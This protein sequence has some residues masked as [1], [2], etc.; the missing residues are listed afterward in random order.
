MA[1]L[2][3]VTSS[4]SVVID[5]LDPAQSPANAELIRNDWSKFLNRHCTALDQ[6]SLPLNLGETRSA[7]TFYWLLADHSRNEGRVVT[8]FALGISWILLALSNCSKKSITM[9]GSFS[10]N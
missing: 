2:S 5:R 3:M 7:S 10:E 6:F 4:R 8:A 9:M 1:W